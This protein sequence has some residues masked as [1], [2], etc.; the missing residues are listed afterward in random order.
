MHGF[1]FDHRIL[2]VAQALA[3]LCLVVRLWWTELYRVYVFFFC[4]LLLGLL[5]SS[6]LA[7]VPLRSPSYVYAWLAAESLIVCFYVLIVLE[8]YA[9]VLRDLPGIAS[10]SRLYIKASVGV[11]ILVSVLLLALEKVPAHAA[12]AFLVFERVIVSSLMVFVLLVMAFLAYY[13]VPLSRNVIVYSIGYAVYFLAKAAGL[14]I[15]T[16]SHQ[17]YSGVSLF[18]VGTSTA[19][20]IFWIFALNR[21]GET[22]TVVV[23]HQWN[24]GDEQQILSQLQAINDSLVRSARK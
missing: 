2:D 24:S 5:Q 1:P 9:I 19:C 7:F 14:L 11:A 17:G 18:L 12:A 23:G 13:P 15:T 8:T 3:L 6:V 20:L 10:L 16:S 21:K 4:Y 22:K